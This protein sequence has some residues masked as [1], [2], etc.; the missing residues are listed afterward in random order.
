MYGSLEFEHILVSF[1][2]PVSCD[3]QLRTVLGDRV[4]MFPGAP[5]KVDLRVTWREF[6]S[7]NAGPMLARFEF[8]FDV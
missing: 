5:L 8:S 6:L 7:A 1:C 4:C 3:V 2:C